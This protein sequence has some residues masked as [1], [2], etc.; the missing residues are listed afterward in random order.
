MEPPDLAAAALHRRLFLG[1]AIRTL[2][3][4]GAMVAAVVLWPGLLCGAWG[5]FLLWFY[6]REAAA[7]LAGLV[8]KR[9]PVPEAARWESRPFAGSGPLVLLALVAVS[10]SGPAP[11]PAEADARR[12]DP[13][14]TDAPR[15]APREALDRAVARFVTRLN[16][17][18]LSDRQKATE[19]LVSL[20]NEAAPHL[21][22]ERAQA[23]S[24]EVVARLDEVLAILGE[25]GPYIDAIEFLRA[26]RLPEA[27]ER[28]DSYTRFGRGRYLGQA[29]YLW[30][31]AESLR[32]ARAETPSAALRFTW[33]GGWR[34]GRDA[35]YGSHYH[36]LYLF[37]RSRGVEEPSFL[38]RALDSYD[39]EISRG[40]P[41]TRY[42]LLCRAALLAAAGRTEEA[43]A[44]LREALA[45]PVRNG[46]DTMTLACYRAAADEREEALRVLA[47]GI[48]HVAR[49]RRK[50]AARGEDP[51]GTAGPEP[52]AWARD[53]NDF[54]SLREDPRFEALVRAGDGR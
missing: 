34:A 51:E 4:Y 39:V 54:D 50:A 12:T 25:E 6:R 28:L 35:E 41:P 3:V 22:A 5:A 38:R 11:A 45:Q 32:Q 31:E 46:W 13:A 20:G 17:P 10:C 21:R 2:L 8:G 7:A 9:P 16:S 43:R 30:R 48:E 19:A 52:R 37:F 36:N 40:S 18:E 26:E 47:E 23:T 49:E 42:A 24:P 44:G 53:S 33:G 27:L 15:E 1:S 14:P 29:R